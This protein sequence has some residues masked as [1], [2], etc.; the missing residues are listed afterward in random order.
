[1]KNFSINNGQNLNNVNPGNGL[2]VIGYNSNELYSNLSEKNELGQIREISSSPYKLYSF[3]LT[4]S[5]TYSPTSLLLKDTLGMGNI[6]WSYS[7]VGQYVG[8]LPNAFTGS[9][10]IFTGNVFNLSIASHSYAYTS[11][12]NDNIYLTVKNDDGLSDDMLSNT[13]FDI[14][15]YPNTFASI[16]NTSFGDGYPV[17]TLPLTSTGTY[18]FVVNWGDGNTDTITSYSQPEVTHN[19]SSGGIYTIT[20]SGQ[21][22][23]W[24]FG[25]G[26]SSDYDKITSVIHW[27]QL[28]LG[29]DGYYFKNCTNLDLSG[30]Y[31]ILDLTGTT[32]LTNMFSDCYV[33]TTVGNLNSWNVS[34]VTNM[35][36]MFLNDQLFNGYISSWNV[37]NVTDMS[38]MFSGP[39]GGSYFNQDISSW[40][41]TNVTNMSSMFNR[42]TSFN[43]P[44]GSWD[45]TNVTNM[46]NMFSDATSFNQPIGSWNVSSVT[47][48]SGIF[49]FTPFDQDISS[50]NVGSVT[51]MS[52]M[53]YGDTSFNQPIGSWNVGSVTDMSA[54]FVN[55]TSFNQDI[56][57]WDVTN[58]TNMTGMF[59]SATSF[60]QPIGGWTVSSVTDFS[61]FMSGKSTA[62][63]SYYDNLLSGWSLQTLN[64]NLTLDMDTIQYTSSG[65]ASR[66]VLTDP[67]NN[68]TIN[69]GGMI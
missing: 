39:K 47:N 31:D 41:V 55:S 10:A 14:R 60:N 57:S 69:D 9:V 6:S 33:L 42:A 20:I 12:D 19:Y 54:M 63:Y 37:T 1:M 35:N 68:W 25:T 44:I 24:S 26:V 21:I 17:I 32:N 13:P 59:N 36:S 28:K 7:S 56:S 11:V 22:E 53:F 50:W 18:N 23:G 40:N 65:S 49:L 62:D 61:S 67:P 29:N 38:Y 51:D 3:L 64:P 15:V 27:G 30:V 5:G 58:V 16:W 43:Q 34:S 4:Q 46:S 2:R 66:L 52:Y 48:M 8:N 45:V